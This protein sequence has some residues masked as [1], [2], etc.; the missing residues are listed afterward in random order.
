MGGALWNLLFFCIVLG[1]LVTIH[2]FG[3]Y[4][5]ARLCGVKVYRFCLGFGPVIFRKVR[6]NGEEFAI[7]LLP[8]GG[9]VKMKGES[10]E[11]T[12]VEGA[13]TDAEKADQ[14]KADQNKA[15]QKKAAQKPGQGWAN[16][17][18][19]SFETDFA[20]IRTGTNPDSAFSTK[21]TAALVREAE[22]AAQDNQAQLSDSFADKKIW[23]RTVI[24]AAGPVFNIILAFLIYIV[25]NSFGVSAH[26]PAVDGIAPGSRAY[27][28][29][30]RNGDLI[31]TVDGRE[32]YTAGDAWMNLGSFAGK[33][34][35][36]TVKSDFGRGPERALQLDLTGFDV[37]E[38]DFFD[39][40]GM[41]QSWGE[42]AADVSFV[43]AD[44]PAARAGL[45]PG[46]LIVAVNGT[47]VANFSEAVA[48]LRADFRKQQLDL[49]GP[50]P[51]EVTEEYVGKALYAP[52]APIKLTIVRRY[53]DE[54]LLPPD[55]AADFTATT[56][57]AFFERGR[58]PKL[59]KAWYE[60]L[61]AVARARASVA[62]ISSEMFELTVEPNV[63]VDGQNG[64][65][66]PRLGMG[67]ITLDGSLV[68]T[69]VNFGPVE[70]V[71]KAFHDTVSD[72]LL[73]LRSLHS[74][75][76]GD[77]GFKAVSGPVA[78][79]T[80]AGETASLGPSFFLKFLALLSI[81]LG[82]LN[83]IPIPVL[84][85]GQLL[86]LAYEKV[87][88]RP[89]SVRAQNFLSVL[90]LSLILGLTLLAIFNDIS[91]FWL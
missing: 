43:E 70:L 5:A 6:K 79:A 83:L 63:T 48:L 9:Y 27:E 28:L 65:V 64:K 44:K 29:G 38:D 50:L 52:Y 73:I 76:S 82:W 42:M 37:I 21:S 67:A 66:Q 23:Q 14:E 51:K 18:S 68:W 86:Y 32:V 35:D 47:K 90:G 57:E 2:E 10:V 74:L 16:L 46:D 39:Y 30:L 59:N 85:G 25:I 56:D 3:H 62:P 22:R 78:I 72:S 45:L 54:G 87:I 69:E 88:G 53:W 89:P 7:A 91:Y 58:D 61:E 60:G 19:G 26:L 24:I 13:A 36:F 49:L 34:V 8:L 71:T 40:I 75:V 55:P 81:N 80:V 84:D 31:T 17:A 41:G 77:I 4:L 12:A 33:E 1:V 11:V 15:A 20:Q